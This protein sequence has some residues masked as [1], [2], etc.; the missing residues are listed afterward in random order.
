[1]YK[2]DDDARY[3]A[4]DDELRSV[5]DL[6]RRIKAKQVQIDEVETM[7]THATAPPDADKVQSGES[8]NSGAIDRLIKLREEAN[9]LIDAYVDKQ[10]EVA[11]KIDLVTDPLLAELLMYRYV[12]AMSWKKTAKKL[13]YS[14]DN[15]YRL[16]RKAIE[17]YADILKVDS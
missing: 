1:M 4:A 17:A 10:Y 6:N 8:D 9:E 16:N 14:V 3:Q 12:A 13:E 2:P 11:G 7:L 15:I 5:Q